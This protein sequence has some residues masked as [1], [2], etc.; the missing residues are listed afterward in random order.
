MSKPKAAGFRPLKTERLILRPLR[1]QD[2]EALHRLVNDWEVTRNLADVPFPY[3]RE[4]ADEWIASTR[5]AAGGRDA[6]TISPS[7]A[8][9]RARNAGRGR[10]PARRCR[11]PS[12]RLGY[13]VGR[14]F[15][16]HGVA[17]EAAGRLARW[18]LANL[19]L[20]RLEAEV[21]ADNAASA[22]VLRRIG[23]R[24]TG[25]GSAHGSWPAAAAQVVAGSRRR[26]TTSSA[27]RSPRAGCR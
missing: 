19:D 15:W 9:G 23:F 12:G 27:S 26:A 25:D 10:R 17:T 6:P 3:P 2:A 4:L 8:G 5:G 11:S 21:T 13:W 16:G 14:A 18:A 22:A 1:P 7:P 20:D 24:Q